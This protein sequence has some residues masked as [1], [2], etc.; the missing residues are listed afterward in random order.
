MRHIF[1][2][3]MS[4]AKNIGSVEMMRGIAAMMVA[5]FH[6]ARGNGDFLPETNLF[7][8]IGAYGW[9]GVEIFFVISGFIITYAMINGGYT[10]SRIHKFVAKRLIRLEPPYIVS[11]IGVILLM[12]IS[13]LSPYYRGKPFSLDWWNV[14]GHLG[15]VNAF[16]GEPWLQDVYWSLAIEFEFYLGLALLFPLL[17]HKNRILST[18]AM[19]ALVVMSFIPTGHAHV[20]EYLPFFCMGIFY[21]MF[22]LGRADKLTFGV[23][24]IAAIAVCFYKYDYILTGLG[25]VS[26]GA[27]AFIKS[28]PK[29]MAW[30]G[31][32]SYSLYL[33]HIP[34][35]GR[36]INITEVLVKNEYLRVCAVF[37]AIAVCLALSWLFYRIV[38]KPFQ[39][40][41]KRIS[42]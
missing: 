31:K 30:L 23:L 8:S 28:V 33:L 15:Y 6:I 39:K 42:Y 19:A 35:G 26:I 32:I 24:F 37:G 29:P 20:F 11:I 1:V 3:S 18:L 17:T 38:E 34:I 14:L 7:F 4:K 27:F 21:S 40:W 13:I 41:S 5:Y 2:A 16:T 22:L 36:I 12:Y 25:L 9:A 10:I